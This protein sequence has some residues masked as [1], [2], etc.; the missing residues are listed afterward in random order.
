MGPVFG[1]GLALT[2]SGALYTRIHY[3]SDPSKRDPGWITAGRA[4]MGAREWDREMEMKEDVWDGLPVFPSYN[5]D[6]TSRLPGWH[7]PVDFRAKAFPVRLDKAVYLG[8]WDA[9]QTLRPAFTLAQLVFGETRAQFQLQGL[10]EVWSDYSLPMETF[11]P[12]VAEAIYAHYPEISERIEHFGDETIRNRSGSRGETA[13]Q[14]AQEHGFFIT[15]MSN[16]WNPRRSAVE[17]FLKRKLDENTPGMVINGHLMRMLRKGF[18]GA[19]CLESKNDAVGET[20]VLRMPE[21]NIY[22]HTHD[23]WQA[24]CLGAK[25]EVEMGGQGVV[26]LGMSFD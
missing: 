13:Q 3:L 8:G 5:E 22:S 23:S 24:L 19:Y 4:S 11:A 18:Q 15:P 14:V 1:C 25:R 9:G 26:Q 16:V 6:I 20:A 17:W 2:E 7:C 21:K 10:L 12:R